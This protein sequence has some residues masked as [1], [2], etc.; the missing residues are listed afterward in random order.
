[1]AIWQAAHPDAWFAGR[2]GVKL[3]ELG[4]VPFTQPGGEVSSNYVQ[5]TTELGYTYPDISNNAQDVIAKYVAK[6]DWVSQ[7]RLTAPASI[8]PTY[9]YK[10]GQPFKYDAATLT[11]IRDAANK[12]GALVEAL[13]IDKPESSARNPTILST[14]TFSRS[15]AQAPITENRVLENGIPEQALPPPDIKE[16]KVQRTWYIDN[17]VPR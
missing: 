8:K 4:L 5:K 7:K 13:D 17:L 11:K 10:T 14:K 6:Y 12:T 3:G 9:A 16:D 15:I 1:M 2:K